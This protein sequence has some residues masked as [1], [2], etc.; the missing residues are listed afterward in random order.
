MMK[1]TNTYKKDAPI[2]EKLQEEIR[3][4][5][6][7]LERILN[8]FSSGLFLDYEFEKFGKVKK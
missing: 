3:C 7:A 4:I 1:M 5:R 2:I 6:C 8:Y